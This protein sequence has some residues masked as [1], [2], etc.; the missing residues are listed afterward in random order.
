[1]RY[2]KAGQ[3]LPKRI[4]YTPFPIEKEDTYPT[5]KKSFFRQVDDEKIVMDQSGFRL[6]EI[7]VGL[8]IFCM[9]W[10]TERDIHHYG[11]MVSLIYLGKYIGLYLFL[12]GTLNTKRVF[13]FNRKEGT[14]TYPEFLWRTSRTIP[15]DEACFI[16]CKIGS[17]SIP[18]GYHLA[19]VRADGLT[20]SIISWDFPEKEFALFVWYMDRNRPLPPGTAFD[21]YRQRDYERR[22]KARFPKPLYPGRMSTP[23]I[24]NNP[25]RYKGVPS[26]INKT[27]REIKLRK[28]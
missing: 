11:A 5:Q 2:R 17:P 1:M 25:R 20:R 3:G 23:D 14:V 16:L 24:D 15:F 12:Y 27:L 9:I 19:I 18:E 7:I 26:D 10:P 28:N 8:F 6:P 22:K 13:I 4:D 21:P